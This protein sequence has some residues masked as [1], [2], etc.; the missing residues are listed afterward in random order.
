MSEGTGKRW[1]W[2]TLGVFLFAVVAIA[3]SVGNFGYTYDEPAYRYSQMLSQQWWERLA[4]GEFKAILE[5][6]ALLYYWPYG[7]HGIN[8][9]PPL[10]GQLNLLTYKL[11]G[12]ILKD[13]P[14]RRMASALEFAVTVTMLFGFMAKRY[15][16]WTGLV[17]GGSLLFMPRVFGQ[18]HLIDTDMPGLMLWA[19]AGLA[20]W[21]GITQEKAGLWRVAVGVLVGLAFVEKMGAVLV[22]LPILGWIAVTSFAPAIKSLVRMKPD[23]GAWVDGIL[24]SSLMIVPL[25]LAYLEIRRLAVAFLTIQSAMGMSGRQIS[26]AS[27]DLFRDHPQ[28][29]MPGGILL[30]PLIVWIVRPRA[31]AR[32]EGRGNAARVG[33]LARASSVWAGDRLARQPKLVARDLASIGT[34]LLDQHRTPRRAPRH[35][36]YLFRSDLR[37]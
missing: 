8:F 7:R 32:G 35:S 30:V 10:A 16:G 34:L 6:D 31:A 21:K 1:G 12:G 36:N 4:R 33:S 15:G 22:V 11:F 27:T 3:P 9:H 26:P 25:G 17:A 5:P 28:T 20:F 18:A 37:I 29:W 24:S 19:A 13:V 2:A 23:R 14:A